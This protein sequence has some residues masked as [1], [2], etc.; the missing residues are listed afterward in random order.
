MRGPG[1]PVGRSQSF[2]GSSC[3]FEP[4]LFTGDVE[5]WRREDCGTAQ[6]ADA[7]FDVIVAAHA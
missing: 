3:V 7:L 2:P 4:E 1:V 6:V 5:M